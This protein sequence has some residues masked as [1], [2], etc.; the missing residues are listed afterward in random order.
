MLFIYLFMLILDTTP[1]NNYCGEFCN[2]VHWLWVKNSRCPM[3]SRKRCS[4]RL[5][6]IG[7]CAS[8]QV[9]ILIGYL[10]R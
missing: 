10:F 4:S 9:W 8:Q 1:I 5:P 3:H 2:N 7:V 6:S